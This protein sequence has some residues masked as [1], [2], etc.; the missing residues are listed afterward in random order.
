MGVTE[1]RRETKP[2]SKK[3][4]SQIGLAW[5]TVAWHCHLYGH[6]AVAKPI[7]H[8]CRLAPLLLNRLGTLLAEPNV[9]ASIHGHDLPDSTVG[10]G[11]ELQGVC[12]PQPRTQLAEKTM[13]VT[14]MP[15]L[16]ALNHPW[17]PRELV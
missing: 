3:R 2:N 8:I 5:A 7:A 17:S 9:A 13:A 6:V 4:S 12:F 16:R 1:T 11:A 14:W 10:S 15:S